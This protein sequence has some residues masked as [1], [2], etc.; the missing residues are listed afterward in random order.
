M[1]ILSLRV[2]LLFLALGI[3]T[4]CPTRFRFVLSCKE[5]AYLYRSNTSA[6]PSLASRYPSC[7]SLAGGIGSA[8]VFVAVPA[9][10]SKEFVENRTAL[11][12]LIF[13]VSGW[14]GYIVNVFLLEVY[15]R[16]TRG[17]DERLRKV[18]EVRRRGPGLEKKKL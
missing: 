13:G 5:L 9:N 7:I 6:L 3:T 15:L 11:L 17:E 10:W 1:Q 4:F 8:D 2:V 14:V 12:N 16:R 18:S